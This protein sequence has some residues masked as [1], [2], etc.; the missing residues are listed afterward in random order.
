MC[1]AFWLHL[2]G[3]FFHLQR[4]VK[5]VLNEHA[6]YLQLPEIITVFDKLRQEAI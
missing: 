5:I 6:L 2:A 1:T 3:Q 4:R